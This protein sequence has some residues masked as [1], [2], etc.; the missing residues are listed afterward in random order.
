MLKSNNKLVMD[1]S[2]HNFGNDGCQT[3][4]M[5]IT[6]KMFITFL[7]NWNNISTNHLMAISLMKVTVET[8]E[9]TKVQ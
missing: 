7:V 1:N 3:D 9:P 6:C 2:L 8:V 4:R 5:I